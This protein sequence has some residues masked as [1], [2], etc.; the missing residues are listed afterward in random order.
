MLVHMGEHFFWYYLLE[1]FLFMGFI[2]LIL[3]C[4]TGMGNMKAGLPHTWKAWQLVAKKTGKIREGKTN[5]QGLAQMH[6]SLQVKL[7]NMLGRKQRNN[8]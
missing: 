2:V 7:N 1:A 5:R 8:S 3:F 4:M 6:L